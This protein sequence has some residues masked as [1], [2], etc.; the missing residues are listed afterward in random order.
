MAEIVT[1]YHGSKEGLVGDIA[2][3][4]RA[5]CDFGR[6]FYLGDAPNQPLT[7][8]CDG[9]MPHLYQCEFDLEGLSIHRFEPTIDWALFVAWNRNVIPI[10]FR[11][12]YD[13]K[14]RPLVE[15]A[16]V[17][18]G[19]I[20]NDRMFV[21]LTWFFE[22]FI[23]DVGLLKALQALNLG[24]QYCAKN[25]NACSRVRVVEDRILSSGE[26]ARLRLQAAEQRQ[27][28]VKMVDRIRREHRRDGRSFYEIMK[29]DVES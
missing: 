4:S 1:L 10:E 2:P 3:T 26:C 15:N 28:A 16:D 12:H 6:G 27:Y 22:E 11:E 23:S 20:A 13:A 29:A 18:Y 8:I 5:A 7:L 14:F 17:I 9:A 24:N 19:K 21:V 25:E